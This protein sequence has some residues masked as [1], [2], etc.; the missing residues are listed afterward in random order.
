MI[1]LADAL[2]LLGTLERLRIIDDEVTPL[3][4]DAPA[5]HP[6]QGIQGDLLKHPRLVPIA[7]PE[8]PP[9]VAVVGAVGRRRATQQ[10]RQPINR[11]AVAEGDRQDQRPEVVPGRSGEGLADGVEKTGARTGYFADSDPTASPMISAWCYK[12][13]RQTKP[14]FFGVNGRCKSENRSV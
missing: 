13:Y 10:L 8:K 4:L 2:H 6:A 3:V 12:P 1:Q 14:F 5:H 11:R 7:V 9:G